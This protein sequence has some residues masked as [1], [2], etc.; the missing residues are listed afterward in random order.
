MTSEAGVRIAA[1]EEQL[2][3]LPHEIDALRESGE[4][5]IAAE[6]ARIRS[7]AEAD[8]ERLLDQTR[9]EIDVQLRLAK[10]ELVNH[11]ADL[12]VQVARER[13]RAQIS[14]DDQRRLVD[15][16]LDQVKPS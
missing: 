2:Q 5:E 9:R 12:A 4:Q 8:R 3:R 11:A 13:I 7:A 15:R 1:L 10:R 14:D 16:Y 6:E